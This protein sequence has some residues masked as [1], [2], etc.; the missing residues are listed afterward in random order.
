MRFIARLLALA[1]LMLA[2]ISAR[3][4]DA[5]QWGEPV[6]GLRLGLQARST[7]VTSDQDVTF[8]VI[9]QNVSQ[10]PITL[11][12]LDTFLL[13][14]GRN[15]GFRE[16]PLLPVL[17]RTNL[18]LGVVTVATSSPAGPDVASL[19]EH[20]LTLAPGQSI[21]WMDVPL[22]RSYYA[23]GP[24][25]APFGRA[26]VEKSALQPKSVYHLHYR[27]ENDQPQVAGAA[28]W[29]GQADT[30]VVDLTV[31]APSTAG[32]KLRG[33]FSFSKPAY[34]L[35]DPVVA[36]FT[37]TNEGAQDINFPAGGDYR[38]TGRHDR[39][40]VRATDALGL[41]VPDP[42]WW[43]TFLGGIG[44][45]LGGEVTV[46]PGMTYREDVPVSQW[47]AFPGPG[48]YRVTLGRTLNVTLGQPAN[49]ASAY[50]RPA[51]SLPAIPIEATLDLTLTE[52]PWLRG[53][54]VVF[55]VVL[56][57]LG[58]WHLWRLWRAARH[59]GLPPPWL[60]SVFTGPILWGLSIHYLASATGWPVT[61][62]MGALVAL[63]V[64]IALL[65]QARKAAA[66]VGG[67]APLR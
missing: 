55:A 50:S 22:G 53:V 41:P 54:H 62:P 8:T 34:R 39:F 52:A 47:C 66:R 9:A 51:S 38:S 49:L 5:V 18:L 35:G 25:I 23:P 16:T 14:S 28:V 2:A 20:T 3:A 58:T 1:V 24:M 64:E 43:R 33:A 26:M 7:S 19:R 31:G 10:Q 67:T 12:T 27:Y 29:T 44:G 30:G 32:I 65:R 37:V 36:T 57:G 6:R 59:P 61:G 42:K 21:T 4:D 13:R 45:G 17:E 63:V 15:D 60:N 56:G 11:P 48:R 40:S 46:K